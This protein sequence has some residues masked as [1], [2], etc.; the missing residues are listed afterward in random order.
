LS[1]PASTARCDIDVV[2]TEHGIADLRGLDDEERR[3]AL[4]ALWDWDPRHGTAEETV[5]PVTRRRLDHG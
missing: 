3:R 2:V 4:I 1:V 5:P